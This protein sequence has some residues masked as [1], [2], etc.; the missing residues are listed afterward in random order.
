MWTT[1]PT[2]RRMVRGFVVDI[3]TEDDETVYEIFSEEATYA[4]GTFP[5][6]E[7]ELLSREIHDEG[8]YNAE[9]RKKLLDRSGDRRES[10]PA[11]RRTT[12]KGGRTSTVSQEKKPRIGR[13]HPDT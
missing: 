9:K 4:E 12:G 8:D 5:R 3:A 13:D 2:S 1:E 10:N 6:Y 7:N 11:R